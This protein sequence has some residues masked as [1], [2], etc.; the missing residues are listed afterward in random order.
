M[1]S[2]YGDAVWACFPSGDFGWKPFQHPAPFSE[3]LRTTDRIQKEGYDAGDYANTFGGTSG[4]CPGMA[5]VVAL[6]LAVNPA[7]TPPEVKA[8]IRESCQKI[9]KKEGE[10]DKDGH[11]V[12]YGYGRIDAGLAVSNALKSS[13]KPSG[14]AITG[15]AHFTHFGEQPLQLGGVLTGQFQ[16]PQKLLGL[17]LQMR[18]AEKGL[19]LRYRVNVPGRG[20][21]ENQSDGEYVG[22]A[23]ARQRIIGF[24]IELEGA[25]AKKYDVVYAARLKG[26]ATRA[27]ASN[28][29]YCGTDKKTGKTVEAIA[30]QIKKRT[31]K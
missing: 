29:Q 17:S 31:Q 16:T 30:V 12:F 28:G 1:Y 5:G 3:G 22:T 11:S 8:I 10:Y 9:D 15:I 21:L 24:A 7:L 2:D 18:A 27:V 6:M 4:A 13:A 20:I 19:K 26:V 14:P 25:A 23:N